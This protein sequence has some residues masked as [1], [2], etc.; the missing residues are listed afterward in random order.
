MSPSWHQSPNGGGYLL[1]EIPMEWNS[2]RNHKRELFRHY[3]HHH[4]FDAKS[5][6]I[7]FLE[8]LKKD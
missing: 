6:A 3:H 8:S 4:H 1:P 5:L 2:K 7:E